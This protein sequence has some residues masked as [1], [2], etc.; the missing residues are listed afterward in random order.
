VQPFSLSFAPARASPLCP[1]PSVGTVSS[2]QVSSF[3][4]L[5]SSCRSS[6]L[7]WA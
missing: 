2:R 3:S 4:L 7:L 5:A 6:A 1:W